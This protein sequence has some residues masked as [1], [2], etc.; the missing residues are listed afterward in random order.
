MTIKT[1]QTQS[2]NIAVITSETPILT[3]VPTVLDFMA[4][5]VYEYDCHRIVLS[6]AAFAEDFFKLST[7]V[8]GE[9][10]QKFVNYGFR[11][12]IIGDFS[13]YTSA[14]LRDFIYESNNGRHLYFVPDEKTALEK[15]SR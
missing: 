8:A 3:D 5:I 13:G 14:P 10:A 12:A 1:V 9:I 2:G 11:V 15:L 7:G 4:N 6:K